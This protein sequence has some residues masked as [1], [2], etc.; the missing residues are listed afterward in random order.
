MLVSLSKAFWH[1]GAMLDLSH[2]TGPELRR[3]GY[4]VNLL[5]GFYEGLPDRQRSETKKHITSALRTLEDC[6]EDQGVTF[7]PD[8]KPSARNFDDVAVRW[9]LSRGACPRKVPGFLDAQRRS[10]R[11]A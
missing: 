2:Y 4:V 9:G 5:Y 8:D 10:Y 7:Y 11:V 1:E 6:P 3:A